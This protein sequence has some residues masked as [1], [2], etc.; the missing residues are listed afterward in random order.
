MR[1]CCRSYS[2][3]LLKTTLEAGVDLNKLNTRIGNPNPKIETSLKVRS[4]MG[5]ASGTDFEMMDRIGL[6][7]P[8]Q[9]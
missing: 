2:T 1:G 3:L 4:A 5:S 6:T 8:L 7:L 9:A